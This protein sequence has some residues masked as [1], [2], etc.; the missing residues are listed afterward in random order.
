MVIV[1]ENGR[2]E[3]QVQK[4]I[5]TLVDVGYDVHRSTGVAHTVIGAV[6]SPHR[7]L[8]PRALESCPACA[9]W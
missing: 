8:D 6:G 7:P 3:E 4:V 2:R 9:R 1:M 5:A